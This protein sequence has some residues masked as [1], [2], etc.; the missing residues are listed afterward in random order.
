MKLFRLPDFYAFSAAGRDIPNSQI[1]INPRRASLHV[2]SD[3][4]LGTNQLGE[5][6]CCIAFANVRRFSKLC[7]PVR[8][9]V[10]ARK[11]LYVFGST[12]QGGGEVIRKLSAQLIKL[13]FG[14]DKVSHDYSSSAF[15]YDFRRELR[16]DIVELVLLR[17]RN[18]NRTREHTRKNEADEPLLAQR[19][20]DK[21][22]C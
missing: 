13:F 18:L 21:E 11:D 1:E 3:D 22:D 4:H 9:V 17:P 20:Q 8:F 7:S 2:A 16:C 15:L 10:Q 12:R 5:H 6:S 19:F 14:A